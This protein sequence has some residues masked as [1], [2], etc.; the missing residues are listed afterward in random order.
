MLKVQKQL[1]DVF[2]NITVLQLVE[3]L[4]SLKD[5]NYPVIN[6]NVEV[7]RFARIPFRII[8]SPFLLGATIQHHIENSR[9]PVTDKIKDNIYVDNIITG[10]DNDNEAVELY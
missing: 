3:S 5:V 9:A 2:C 8:S 4:D 10:A 6:D 1:I 7:Y